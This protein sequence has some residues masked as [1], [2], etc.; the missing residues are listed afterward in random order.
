[1]RSEEPET[2]PEPV[3]IPRCVGDYARG[4]LRGDHPRPH[5]EAQDR[6]SARAPPPPLVLRGS[7]TLLLLALLTSDPWRVLCIHFGFWL[8]CFPCTS[9]ASETPRAIQS[10]LF[11]VLFHCY[12]SAEFA[13]SCI[14]FALSETW[15]F[16]HTYFIYQ[17]RTV[18]L[19]FS[20]AVII[21]LRVCA[22]VLY[23]PLAACRVRDPHW[24]H[25]LHSSTCSAF[26][27]SLSPTVGVRRSSRRSAT[28]RSR[29]SSSSWPRVSRKCVLPTR[30]TAPA[31]ACLSSLDHRPLAARQSRPIACRGARMPYALYPMPAPRTLRSW[32]LERFRV[33]A[34][35][36]VFP[37][38]LL[39]VFANE[40]LKHFGF[41]PNFDVPC[42]WKFGSKFSIKS[43]IC[44][45]CLWKAEQRAAEFERQV[46]KLQSEVDRL[47]GILWLSIVDT[48]VECVGTVVAFTI[49]PTRSD[50]HCLRPPSLSTPSQPK[51]NTFRSGQ[52]CG[53]VWTCLLH[54][55]VLCWYASLNFSLCSWTLPPAG[56][57][58]CRGRRTR[59]L[60]AS[61][62]AREAR[63][64]ARTDALL[65]LLLSLSY[66]YYRFQS[67]ASGSA[68]V[69]G[70]CV[71]VTVL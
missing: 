54:D 18:I 50:R 28:R 16:V 21:D 35:A 42:C 14:Y 27:P 12:C 23:A 47:E 62:G 44:V 37:W 9:F 71:I 48:Y 6:T 61:G 8:S 25:V 22:C 24:L 66:S 51:E 26:C 43:S 13:L 40:I 17:Q 45:C 10:E 20:I 33:V 67:S 19:N 52:W 15:L 68:V 31:T 70:A 56:W 41:A 64:S 65:T 5:R 58:A 1:M 55:C 49:L 57:A 60:Q 53:P 29:R 34:F 39:L 46:S 32:T 38:N 36:E 69:S 59:R 11:F 3:R 4:E 30:A 2:E 63:R 7:R